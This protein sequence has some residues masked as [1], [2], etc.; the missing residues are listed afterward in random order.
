M[1]LALNSRPGANYTI[2]LDF[3]GFSFAGNWGNSSPTLTPGVTPTYDIDGNPSSF[4]TQEL[5]NI[6]EIWA[7]VAEKYSEFNINVTTVDPA[8]AAGQAGNDLSRQTYY[9]SVV[10]FMHTVI[11]G[12]GSWDA[13]SGGVSYIG[14][15]SSLTT[16]GEHTN[17]VFAG[18]LPNNMQFI[19]EGAAHENGH[20]LG[21]Q[22]QSIY[23]GNNLVSEYDPG[24]ADRAP[25]MG[26]AN[27]NNTARG[28]WKNGIADS[29]PN[30][31]DPNKPNSYGPPKAQNDIAALLD[32]TVNPGIAVVDDGI[33]HD[34]SSPTAL[35]LSGTTV[36]YNNAKGDINYHFNGLGIGTYSVD[37]FSFRAFNLSTVNLRVNAGGERI[38][39][40]VADPGATLDSSLQ[41]FD[42]SGNMVASAVTGNLNETIEMNL[43]PGNYYAK[44]FSAGDPLHTGYFDIGSYFL[45]G[46]VRT[47][48]N[49]TRSSGNNN[50]SEGGNWLSNQAPDASSLVGFVP[51]RM[52][53]S[54]T[55]NLDS[56]R[57]IYSLTIANN[58]QG[59]GW[60][61]TGTNTLTVGGDESIGKI[62][63]GGVGTHVFNGP[64][65][66]GKTNS[67]P[68]VTINSGATVQLTGQS[69]ASNVRDLIL[70]GTGSL[71]LDNG[72]VKKTSRYSVGAHNIFLN[73]SATINLIANASGGTYALSSG[74]SATEGML[75]IDSGNAGINVDTPSGATGSTLRFNALYHNHR[76]TINFT[77]SGA[78][79]LG[80]TAAIDPWIRF[81]NA[82]Y[83]T[84]GVISDDPATGDPGNVGWALYNG[85]SFAGFNSSRGI[86]A[87]A[88]TNVSGG[89][90]TAATQN[91]NLVGNATITGAVSY[92]T[93]KISP[94]AAGQSLS[95]SG[96]LETTG[97]LLVGST[98]YSIDV[99]ELGGGGPRNVFVTN[100]ATT[101][102][103][104]SKL[105]G[106]DQSIT[107]SGGGFVAL[108]ASSNQVAFTNRQD[109]NIVA[110][111]LRARTD[112]ATGNFGGNNT[113]RFRGGVFEVD[114]SSS[115]TTTF[116]R[117]L[118]TGAGKVNWAQSDTDL[119]EGGFSAI[120]GQLNVQIGGGSTAETLTWGGTSGDSAF[121]IRDGQSLVFGSTKSDSVVDWKN[122]L[123]LDNGAAGDYKTREIRVIGGV[124]DKT[125]LEAPIAGTSTTELVKTGSGT[126]Q[127]AGDGNS[128]AG[129]TTIQSGTLEL[130]KFS[131][132]AILGDSTPVDVLVNGG[133][134]RW[135]RPSQ[136]GLITIRLTSGT[137]DL[138]GQSD[139]F[140][141]LQNEGGTFVTGAGGSLSLATVSWTAGTNT[142][143]ANS[144]VS[145]AEATI[146]GGTNV[147]QG[148]LAIATSLDITGA[149][150]TL[151]SDATSPGGILL[152]NTTVNI[153]SHASDTTAHIASGGSAA[154]AGTITAL[155]TTTCAFN[156]EQGFT[157]S[158]IDLDVGARIINPFSGSMSVTKSG[159]GTLRLS[160]ASTYTGGTT[161]NAGVLIVA[162]SI[163]G[164]V[165]VNIGG[166]LAGSGAIGGTVTVNGLGNLTPGNGAPGSVMAS[167]GGLYNLDNGA[168]VLTV[169]R[170][171]LKDGSTTEIELGGTT[172]G[173]QFDAI[174]STGSIKPT[175]AG[176]LDVSLFNHFLPKPGDVFDI[177]DW[178]GAGVTGSFSSIQLALDGHI[179]WNTSQLYT[180]GA[181]SVLATYYAGDFNRDNHVDAADILAEEKAL[182]D[183]SGYE[184]QY[185]VLAANVPLI[186]DINGDGKFNNLDLQAFLNLLQ[187]GGGSAEPVPEPV[188]AELMLLG[189][190]ALIG[191]RR[192]VKAVGH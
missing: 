170:L 7:R 35:P 49:W 117:G 32:T 101:L 39:P 134:L 111:T 99:G 50:W 179:A 24:D 71:V 109:I 27:L 187:S 192:F 10:R 83:L 56:S 160:S 55:S 120:H 65:I 16:Q 82:P 6:K 54:T 183:L 172:R 139:S 94:S 25:I 61:F 93:L 52:Y 75:L 154:L 132:Y 63:V 90:T 37:F 115:G 173:S 5:N 22:H 167:Y 125:I 143:S 67:E 57:S 18:Q 153:N 74:S 162:G 78:G 129:L 180:T 105:S 185:G 41:I 133:T 161:I 13:G 4:S 102:S 182:T 127:F 137:V 145:I 58:D 68:D 15:T 34:S 9:D 149:T 87:V 184:S 155:S 85:Q 81:T 51:S 77:T 46:S 136:M 95:G 86:V 190:C 181:L 175:L 23:N 100:P 12:N 188:S 72:A 14:V 69:T 42:S 92:N 191:F 123:N 44:V 19:G 121:F 174:I 177:L 142:I 30:N 169:G 126:L 103:I 31:P 122:P 40:G 138:N 104:S 97:L 108:T 43:A 20:G 157:S 148:G 66:I 98:D 84:N 45:T 178:N 189:A 118:G 146:T 165:T 152:N 164:T 2:Y 80:G 88:T 33:S 168:G 59:G 60:T 119:G 158:G 28:L 171:T 53:I 150:L 1:P 17:F 144:Q 11:G 110:G 151:Q 159:A 140:T 163:S 96:T 29:N 112:G 114:S 62:V 131:G 64:S 124:G 38:T 106:T 89:L 47:A 176:T 73:G 36:N 48:S 113:I 8:V 3:G 135:L 26:G 116:T 76:A 141:S 107:I 147:V 156:V 91:S 128:Y 70:N 186:G 79:V 21:L 166:T 130:N